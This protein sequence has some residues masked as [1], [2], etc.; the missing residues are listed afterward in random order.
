MTFR[1]FVDN[2][3]CSNEKLLNLTE[4]LTNILLAEGTVLL[5]LLPLCDVQ[6]YPSWGEI[7]ASTWRIKTG[8]SRLRYGIR[9]RRVPGRP[10]R[11]FGVG[12]Q[13]HPVK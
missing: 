7:R 9:D 8:L 5:D 12:L 4:E 1:T 10:G 2:S 11:G 3:Y 6:I 13:P